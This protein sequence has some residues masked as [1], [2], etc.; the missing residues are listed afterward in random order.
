VEEINMVLGMVDRFIGSAI[1]LAGFGLVLFGLAA[2][3]YQCVLRLEDGY[4]TPLEFRL[5]WEWLG[6]SELAVLWPDVERLQTTILNLPLGV[7]VFLCGS[8]AIYLGRTFIGAS[9]ARKH[10][11]PKEAAE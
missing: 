8:L 7:G 4:W 2:A 1:K 5:A 6:R 9:K 11:K 3:S 10:A